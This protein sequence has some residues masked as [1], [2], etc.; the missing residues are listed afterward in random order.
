MSKTEATRPVLFELNGG[1][2]ALD[3]V[4]TLDNRFGPDGPAELL[5][6]YADL[7]RFLQQAN[8]LS[9]QRTK[10]LTDAATKDTAARALQAARELREAIAATLYSAVDGRAP[11]AASIRTLE[12]YFLSANRHRQ[13][14]WTHSSKQS[15]RP[16]GAD[17]VWRRGEAGVE[18]PVWVLAQA[19]SDLMTSPAL[20]RLRACGSETC[21][22]V[23]LDTSKN[24]S[25]R[26]CSMKVCGNRMK[27]RRFHARPAT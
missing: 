9:A 7:L 20:D 17:W 15:P 16:W 11:A 19:A 1:H 10:L 23:F 3:F 24:H 5:Q 26:W 13:L 12:R 14:Q 8:L 21:R 27:A 18:L 4:N 6:S 25:R 2:P 22:W